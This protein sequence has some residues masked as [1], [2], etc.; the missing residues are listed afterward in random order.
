MFPVRFEM[1]LYILFRRTSAFK[2]V[3]TGCSRTHLDRGGPGQSP[4]V[5]P[6]RRGL[7]AP[8]TTVKVR[9]PFNCRNWAR[10]NARCPW[11]PAGKARASGRSGKLSGVS[12]GVPWHSP[13]PLPPVGCCSQGLSDSFRPLLSEAFA[14]RV[15]SRPVLKYWP[16][17]RP[18]R[19]VRPIVH[20]PDV[21]LGIVFRRI[22]TG[23][24]LRHGVYTLEQ[25]VFLYDTY[26][27]YGS[28]GKCRRKFRRKFRDE[29]FPSRQTIH[30]LVNKLRTTGLLRN[31]NISDECLLRSS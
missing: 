6:S 23:R 11:P 21:G 15:L 3:W 12:A 9:P 8:W 22:S 29:R 27:K 20:L 19:N 10:I 5:L 13:L 30:N 2:G 14:P 25:R 1:D 7:K 4:E 26:M 16:R 28:A 18:A 24:G 31:K 17:S